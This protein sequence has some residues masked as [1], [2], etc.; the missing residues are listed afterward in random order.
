MDT[1]IKKLHETE[2]ALKSFFVERDDEVHGLTLALLANVN[3]LLLGPPGTAKSN[4]INAWSSHIKGASIFSWLLTRFSTP[5][6]LFGPYSLKGLEDDKFIRI[7]KGKLPD[8]NVVF[9]DEIFKCNPGV[10][11]SLLTVLNEGVFFNDGIAEELDI[12]TVVGASNEI[13][14][15]ED[16]LQALYDRFVLKYKVMPIREASNFLAMLGNKALYEAN[17]ELTFDEIQA[18]HQKVKAIEFTGVAQETY[19]DLRTAF[20]KTG[21]IVTDRTYRTSVRLLQAEAL[22]NGRTEIQEEDF[23]ILQ[24]A[25][26]INPEQH[27]TVYSEI[28]AVTNPE[29]NK[30][31]EIYMDACEVANS[32]LGKKDSESEECL[33]VSSKLKKAKNQLNDISSRMDRKGRDTAD[34]KKKELELERLLA[35]VF[36][37]NLGLSST[38]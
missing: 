28:L 9:L 16:N 11:N 20:Q 13:P 8:A 37:E 7:T 30:V 2:T 3:L 32:V 23:E 6:E 21:I 36:H 14:E 15:D 35:R 19:R 34:V 22:F 4:L 26:W 31:L 24:H 18:L 25:F 1:S 38:T 17:N 29:K 12:L 27:R 33:E 5:E 10:L